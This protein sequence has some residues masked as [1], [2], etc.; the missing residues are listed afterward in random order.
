MP[1][2]ELRTWWRDPPALPDKIISVL[3]MILDDPSL[4]QALGIPHNSRMKVR[5][6]RNVEVKWPPPEQHC[7][8]ETEIVCLQWTMRSKN[9]LDLKK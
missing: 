6:R 2:E 1:T 4:N 9:D 5:G 8:L 7:P 3:W